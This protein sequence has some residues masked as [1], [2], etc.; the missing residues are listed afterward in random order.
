VVQSSTGSRTPVDNAPID[1]VAKMFG[2][3]FQ[4][5]TMELGRGSREL[6][7][8]GDG[9]TNVGASS[10]TCMKQ[11][12][13]QSVIGKPHLFSER[14]MFGS[15]FS[16]T[17]SGAHGMKIGF[18]KR[19]M[20]PG[21]NRALG[22]AWS[23]PIVCSKQ[24][25]KISRTRHLDIVAGLSNVNAIEPSD[26]AF[27]DKRR[28]GLAGKL[29]LL[30]NLGMNETSNCRIRSDDGKIINLWTKENG[31][32]LDGRMTD[33]LFMGGGLKT[34]LGIAQN[35]VDVRFPKASSFGMTLESTE[36]REHETALETNGVL[37]K[38]PI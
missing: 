4:A 5:L 27:V 37:V 28:F 3:A 9:T 30:T 20:G 21:T 32:V 1:G 11:F 35:G 29:E 33:V 23:R 6:G 31:N 18:G 15:V 36:K 24:T 14:S 16:K 10:D 26:K 13:K 22:G 25:T 2:D 8:K 34:K 7:K 38:T 19:F 12:T 17:R